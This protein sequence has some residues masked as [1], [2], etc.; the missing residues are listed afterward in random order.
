MQTTNA[1]NATA[2]PKPKVNFGRMLGYGLSIGAAILA[3]Y[4]L[5][6]RVDAVQMDRAI[7]ALLGR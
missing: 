2:Q 1:T 4:V 5:V 7:N 3:A 6:F